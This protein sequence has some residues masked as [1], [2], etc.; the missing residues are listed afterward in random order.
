M[1]TG[2]NFDHGSS[3]SFDVENLNETLN[4]LSIFCLKNIQNIIK[5]GKISDLYTLSQ[6]QMRQLTYSLIK[7]EPNHL[8]ENQDLF[9]KTVFGEEYRK[10]IDG[11]DPVR[12]A[13][14]T[15]STP[16]EHI[17]NALLNLENVEKNY[18]NFQSL[19]FL[20]DI[21]GFYKDG[22]VKM[23]PYTK[24]DVFEWGELVNFLSQKE[25]YYR[26]LIY[27]C[28]NFL[29][30]SRVS[31]VKEFYKII[32][33]ITPSQSRNFETL[34]RVYPNKTLDGTGCYKVLWLYNRSF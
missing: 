27:N 19:V 9:F 21:L 24:I 7:M 4:F 31:E 30:F 11:E 15:L 34:L 1:F 5:G 8:E 32:E 25:Q 23:E 12:V 18:T 29:S 10:I 33:N 6:E 26:D 28:G 22:R 14:F 13:E 20:G 17:Q 16:L 3:L 2:S